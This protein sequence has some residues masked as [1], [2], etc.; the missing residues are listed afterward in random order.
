MEV[1]GFSGCVVNEKG[2]RTTVYGGYE[3]DGDGPY[4]G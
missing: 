4:A 2:I 3:A 1:V